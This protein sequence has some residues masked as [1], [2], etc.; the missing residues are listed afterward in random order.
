MIGY[1]AYAFGEPKQRK[2]DTKQK[3]SQPT[4]NPT[5]TFEIGVLSPQEQPLIIQS[6]NKKEKKLNLKPH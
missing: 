3:V 4:Q 1:T 5:S 6:S 2:K